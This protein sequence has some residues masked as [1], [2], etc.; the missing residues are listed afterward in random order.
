MNIKRLYPLLILVVILFLIFVGISYVKNNIRVEQT[1][2]GIRW[3][4][5]GASVAERVENSVSGTVRLRK[6]GR[7]K[8]RGQTAATEYCYLDGDVYIEGVPTVK[9]EIIFNERN[10][11]YYIF[12]DPA[13]GGYYLRL[14][15]MGALESG[16][17]ISS[18]TDGIVVC[19]MYISDLKFT[20]VAVDYE[21]ADSDGVKYIAAPAETIDEA[22][23]IW[24]K[25]RS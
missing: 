11:G 22:V 8:Y 19:T 6:L 12:D 15:N 5:N 14:T 24:E 4:D 9:S 1:L 23:E 3:T 25:L 16:E 17:A 7:D 20:E 2:Y 10:M 21:S 13:G 18:N